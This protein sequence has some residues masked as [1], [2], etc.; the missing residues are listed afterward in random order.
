LDCTVRID[1]TPDMTGQSFE[2]I[3]ESAKVRLVCLYLISRLNDTYLTS[4]CEHLIDD[5]SD[6]IARDKVVPMVEVPKRV[7]VSGVRSTDSLPFVYE[8]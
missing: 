1:N 4:A 3:S 5:Y 6:Q 2:G 8:D 7:M